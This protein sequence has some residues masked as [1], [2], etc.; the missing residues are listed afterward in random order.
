VRDGFEVYC[1]DDGALHELLKIG[2][3]GSI[4]AAS[5]VSSPFNAR[6]C[7]GV[8]T[9]AGE[10]AQAT[11]SAIRKAVTSVA[12]IPGLKALMARHSGDPAWENVRPP[13]TKLAAEA[14]GKLFAAFDACEVTLAQA[15]E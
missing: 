3:A 10:A 2:G 15:A 7:A 8:S 1:G 13:F 12:L 9:A 5:N 4:S 6:V 11:L 14:R